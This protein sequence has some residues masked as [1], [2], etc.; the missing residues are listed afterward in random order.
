MRE[1][2]TDPIFVIFFATDSLYHAITHQFHL[3]RISNLLNLPSPLSYYRL[4][5]DMIHNSNPSIILNIPRFPISSS[6]KKWLCHG[7]FNHFT[8]S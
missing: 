5:E 3:K 2:N 1:N 8:K 6:M 4:L 7:D